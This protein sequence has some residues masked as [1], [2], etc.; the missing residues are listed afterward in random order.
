ML[1]K[2]FVDRESELE[3]INELYSDRNGLFVLYGRRRI[4]KTELVKQ[5]LKDKEGF[6]FLARQQ[7]LDLEVERIREEFGKQFNV[8]MESDS[9][10]DVIV[11]M[12]EKTGGKSIIV[13]DEFP[14]W[15]E[16]DRTVL[17][18]LQSTWDEHLEGKEVFLILT[19]SSVGMMET[20]VLDYESP[21]YGRRMG[22]LKLDELPVGSLSDFLPDYSF[23]DLIRV[24]G[25]A[26]GIPL[27]LREFDPEKT[28][29][30]NIEDTFLNNLNLLYEEAEILLREE[31]RKPNTYFNIMEA[32]VNGAT[33]LNEIGNRSKV[34]ITNVSKYLKVLE[35]LNLIK[36][37]TPITM[38]D[39]R[40]NRLYRIGDN[41]F[42]FWLTFVYPNQSIVE[43]APEKAIKTIQNEYSTYMG[44]IFEQVCRKVVERTGDYSNVG[45]WWYEEDEIDVVGLD[46]QDSEILA[47]ECKWRSSLIGEDVLSSLEDS[48]ENVRWRNDSRTEKLAIFSKSGFTQGLE[49]RA[50]EREDLELFD[51]KR[52][53]EL[54]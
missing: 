1:Q 53:E 26:G 4:G 47:G 32:I 40:K 37:E 23:E 8:H 31:L 24:Y 27:Y 39:K 22:Q 38:P 6:Y 45:C 33:K 5:F 41:Y 9:L 10:E 30:E 36:R 3:G 20:H 42:R 11:E 21:L 25:A 54:M 48:I 15:I 17:S 13:I 50:E 16:Q 34:D 14:Y 49:D 18:I 43:A 52:I 35:R 44:P 2:D 46:K 29:Y 28:F 7:D 19:G 12:V 51:L